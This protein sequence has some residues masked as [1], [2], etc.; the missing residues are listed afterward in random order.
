[1]TIESTTTR[2]A[3]EGNGI[4]RSFP[5]PFPLLADS[6]VEV[7]LTD[8]DVADSV[9]M[10]PL[11]VGYRVE[12]I[13]DGEPCLVYPED[14]EAPALEKGRKL[15]IIRR[16][17]LIQQTNL[18]NGGNL[19]AET[20]ETQFDIITMQMQQLA[21]DVARA[22][23][24]PPYSGNSSRDVNE[25]LA[26]MEG[27]CQRAE[28]AALRLEKHDDAET[29]LG[30]GGN[31]AV[32]WVMEKN[33]TSGD[34][35]RIP[36]HYPV[37]RDR[38]IFSVDGVLCYPAKPPEKDAESSDKDLMAEETPQSEVP[39]SAVSG[40]V[41]SGSEPSKDH[42]SRS[43]GINMGTQYEEIAA[44]DDFSN[45]IRLFFPLP[46]GSVCHALVLGTGNVASEEI[47]RL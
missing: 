45:E 18:E 44:D 41:L 2:V 24:I 47:N 29:L 9:V 46:A 42:L 21:D 10:K 6:H 1:M 8:K 16:L 32:T 5:I 4:T 17:P 34:V 30:G 38:L 35:L 12:N 13:P 19:H 7:Y 25:V 20:L 22:V 14:A 31:I 15:T 3:Y 36:A 43:D 39:D 37:G 28:A 26:Q 11:A 40:S 27:L 23:K 33:L